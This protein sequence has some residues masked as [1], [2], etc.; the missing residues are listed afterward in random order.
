MAKNDQI[1]SKQNKRDLK[2]TS[3]NSKIFLS[4]SGVKQ[5]PLTL[6]LTM[7]GRLKVNIQGNQPEIYRKNLNRCSEQKFAQSVIVVLDDIFD[8]PHSTRRTAQNAIAAGLKCAL[9]GLKI[10]FNI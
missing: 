6:L 10:I 9:Q 5:P 1:L 3:I 4:K 7:M 8:Q 2:L